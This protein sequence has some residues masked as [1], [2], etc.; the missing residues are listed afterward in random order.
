MRVAIVLG[1]LAVA[2]VANAQGLSTPTVGTGESSA[3][4]LDPSAVYFNPAMSAFAERGELMLGGTLVVGDIR[5]RRSYE[6]VYQR[7]DSFDFQLP[8]APAA[9]EP[10]K[11]GAQEQV[12]ANPVAAA[13]T[14]FFHSPLGDS[15]LVAGFGIYA[16]YA[17]ILDFPDDGP[18]RF[19]LQDAA[20]MVVDFTP[21]LAYR[22]HRAFSLGVGV[23]Y[24]LGFAELSRVQDFATVG[25]VGDA[26][27]NPPINQANDFGADAPT[28]VRELDVTARPF[29]LRE[30][31]E[32]TATFHVGIASHPIDALWLG[33]T[34]QHG[35]KMRF[36]GSF[37]LDMDDDFF[38]QDLASQGLAFAPRIAGPATLAIDLPGS[39][40]FA[41]KAQVHP[42]VQLGVD[43]QYTLWSSVDAF[44]VRVRSPDLAQP[45]LGIPGTQEI[46][47]ERRWR[48]TVGVDLLARVDASD[49][50][51]LYVRGGYRQSAV[52]D[53]T[54]DVASPD[55]NRVVAVGGL[56]LDLTDRYSLRGEVGVQATPEREVRSSDHDVA[57][58]TYRLTIVHGGL[59]LH[60]RL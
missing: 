48:N 38:T 46:R 22:F 33:L 35:A 4:T 3:A 6:G 25:V 10:D 47:L 55:G 58:G 29:R 17:A 32:H 57:N 18:Q 8:I 9:V 16:P 45:Q 52:P 56:V 19:A 40:R 27:A 21:T 15:G 24:V 50:V 20:I 37:E 14:L 34:Y 12:R 30:A 28:G 59:V 7:P 41:A 39:L 2:G 42:R 23:S 43:L 49:D 44:V 11:R 51:H 31:W 60:A 26:L 53:E 54:I 13:P 1:A 36:D 5:Y